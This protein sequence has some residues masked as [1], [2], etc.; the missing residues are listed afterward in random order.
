MGMDGSNEAQRLQQ[1]EA[2]VDTQRRSEQQLCLAASILQIAS[3]PVTSQYRSSKSGART[4]AEASLQQVA[5][6]SQMHPNAPEFC[7]PL[8]GSGYLLGL[9]RVAGDSEDHRG[10]GEC[11]RAAN[12]KAQSDAWQVPD[13][14]ESRCA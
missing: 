3:L 1:G 13:V 4:E 9:L 12:A 8:H 5:A 11:P 14:D 6:Q 10:I 2:A 7:S